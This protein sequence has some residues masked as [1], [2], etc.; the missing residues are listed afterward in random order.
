MA[1]KKQS[2]K[3]TKPVL[4]V[5]E[6]RLLPATMTWNPA[7][8]AT[9]DWSTPGAGPWGGT[10]PGEGDTALFDG[11][12]SNADCV[13]NTEDEKVGAINITNHY[14]GT[15]SIK[16]NFDLMVTGG[17]LKLVSDLEC[18]TIAF[19][20][21]SKDSAS[22][23]VQQ[24]STMWLE[25]VEFISYGNMGS[26][27]INQ[28]GQAWIKNG[29]V[30]GGPEFVGIDVFVGGATGTKGELDFLNFENAVSFTAESVVTVNFGG[31]VN[32]EGDASQSSNL[33]TTNSNTSYFDNFGTIER[34]GPGNFTTDLPILNDVDVAGNKGYIL[35][36]SSL[37]STANYGLVVNGWAPCTNGYSIWQKGGTIQI[38]NVLATNTS[39]LEAPNGINLNNGTLFSWSGGVNTLELDG[40]SLELHN[41]AKLSMSVDAAGN[42]GHLYVD[43][44]VDFAD[45]SQFAPS[46]QGGA[47]GQDVC[48][49]L[50]VNENLTIGANAICNVDTV[51]AAPPAGTV[52][53]FIVVLSST[54]SISGKFDPA[55][56]FIWN[57]VTYTPAL[58]GDTGNGPTVY[59]LT[60]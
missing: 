4:E 34:D 58:T 21:T 37:T 52:Y 10:K 49:V 29:S 28:S 55:T 53:T 12:K 8:G 22:L 31:T 26:I 33:I 9:M 56:G 2:S 3:W 48:N 42:Y 51:G 50:E 27:W 14:S 59:T 45:S 38:G 43:G 40:S 41:S 20:S 32:F 36:N 60:K 1:Q 57:G 11:S 54:G 6:D 18:G 24:N 13:I 30:N 23:I 25:S 17:P 44:N 46:V 5:L 19:D 16:G 47:S 39:S 15:I 7:G 35:V